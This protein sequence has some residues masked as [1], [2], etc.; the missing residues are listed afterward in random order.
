MKRIFKKGSP[1]IVPT[2]EADDV[3]ISSEHLKA[4]ILEELANIDVKVN[5][6][7]EATLKHFESIG[8][9]MK[10]HKSIENAIQKKRILRKKLKELQ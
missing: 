10:V 6:N 1:S 2:T 5:R 9:P 3:I 8:H 7:F 4:E